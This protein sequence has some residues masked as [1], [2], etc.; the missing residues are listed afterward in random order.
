MFEGF[1]RSSEQEESNS[2]IKEVGL[3]YRDSA[4]GFKNRLVYFF[5]HFSECMKAGWDKIRAWEKF[6]L[7]LVL[8]VCAFLCYAYTMLTNGFVVAVN[9]DYRLQGMAFIYNGYDDWHYFFKTGVFPMWDT[10]GALGVDNITGYSFYYLF[11]PFF[12]ALL[13]WPRAWLSQM[14]AIFMIVKTVLSGLFMYDYLGSFHITKSTRKIGAL[15]Y[16]FCGW[17][18]FYLWFFHMAEIVTFLPLMLWGVEKIIQKKDPRL[19]TV[20]AF[21]IGATNYQFLAIFMV[22]SFFYALFRYFHTFKE[23][24][25]AG[26]WAVIGIGFVAFLTGILICCFIIIPSYL[27]IKSMP[28]ISTSGTFLAQFQAANG[29]W[30]K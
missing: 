8:T 30:A 6:D 18:W 22:F 19:F 15:A 25:K 27:Q 17:G 16:A 3:A 7:L 26:N 11:D 20:A 23:R 5:T 28:R 9:G 1:D 24:D 14:Q 21:L 10:S 13:I 29:V 2:L 12:L 4:V